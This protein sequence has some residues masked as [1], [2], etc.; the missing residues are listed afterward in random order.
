MKRH[1]TCTKVRIGK[2]VMYSGPYGSLEVIWRSFDDFKHK[3]DE[4]NQL[5]VQ[6]TYKKTYYMR[7]GKKVMFSGPYGSL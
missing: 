2:K 7:F 5:S 3:S 4:P 1:I 6:K